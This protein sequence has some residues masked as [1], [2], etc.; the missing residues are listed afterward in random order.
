MIDKRNALL[1][2]LVLLVV[3]IIGFWLPYQRSKQAPTPTDSSG[4]AEIKVEYNKDGFDPQTLTVPVGTTVAWSN[5][6]GRPMWVASDP[7]PT[8]TDL[9]EFD[10]LRII[11]K[12]PLPF[13]WEAE[14]HGDAIY[15]Y[16]FTAEG[17]WKYHNHIYPQDR[18]TVI[19]TP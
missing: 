6:S 14:A 16:T 4:N 17:T 19:V 8:H 2:F 15:E 1:I 7:H 5:R 13:T 12:L 11:N 9:K 10:Q 18:G 3:G